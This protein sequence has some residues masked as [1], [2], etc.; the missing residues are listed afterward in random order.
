MR[1]PARYEA[2]LR[3]ILERLKQIDGRAPVSIMTCN[4]D[5]SDPQL[6]AWLEEGLSLETHTI[7]HPCP[8]LSGGDFDKAK[9]TYDRCVDLMHSI[10]KSRPV[11][12]RFP[13][14]D[15]LNTPS[16]RAFAEIMGRTT[17]K[18]NFLQLSSSVCS[19]LTSADGALPRDLVLDA[20]GRERF[21]KYVPFESFVNKV[22]NYPYPFV[23]GRLIWEFPCATPDDWQAQNL[24]QPQN[25]KTLADMQAVIDAAVLKR[26]T[27]NFVFHPYDWIRSDQMA[28][29]VDYADTTYGK[30]VK[31]LNFR[32]CIERLNKNLLAGHA[33][34]A[35]DGGDNGVRLL[36]VNGDGYLDVVIGNEKAR[37]TRIWDPG[38]SAWREMEFPVQLVY[39]DQTIRSDAGVRFGVLDASGAA[40]YVIANGRQLAVGRFMRDRWIPYGNGTQEVDAAD[41]ASIDITADGR[42]NGVRLRDVDGDGICEILMA[43][44]DQ[45]LIV[46]WDA[47]A[48]R[49]QRTDAV[50]PEPIVDEQGRDAGLRLVDL[51]ADGH[52][53]IVFSNEARY[54][55]HLFE[56]P[57]NGWSRQVRA[58]GRGDEG[59]IPMIVKSGTNNGAWFAEGHMWLQNEDTHRLPDGVDRRTLAELLGLQ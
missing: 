37:M 52:D 57:K 45:R 8:C 4:V 17:Q 38:A 32:E 23:I 29:L 39:V 5:P 47:D 58:G 48:G 44:P 34:R 2:Y 19:I 28:A 35:V 6:Q 22:Y 59:A 25:P 50:F 36:D 7:D 10:P 40:G 21:E 15:S 24:Q 11:A 51:N 54:S 33:L 3:P 1:E 30:R 46:R 31:F 14:C 20:D 42:D 27:A 13:C 49:C 16:P 55:V 56:S 18:G 9:D 53:D 41:V 12:F 43:R 26:G